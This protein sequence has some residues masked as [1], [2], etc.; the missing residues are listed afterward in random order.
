MAHVRVV[1]NETPRSVSL[2]ELLNEEKLSP[3]SNSMGSP[4][5]GQTSLETSFGLLT[6][7]FPAVGLLEKSGL[8]NT[9][10][11]RWELGRERD[12]SAL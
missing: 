7:H 5:D 4:A 9:P 3:L 1:S 10:R 11:R 12:P 8:R 2:R 6:C